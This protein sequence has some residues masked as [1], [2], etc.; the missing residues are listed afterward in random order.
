MKKRFSYLILATVVLVSGC[1]PQNRLTKSEK[2]DGWQLLF[3]GVTTTGWRT[4]YGTGFPSHGWMVK[5][6]ELRGELTAGSEA[7]DAGDIVTLKK[8]K[9]FELVFEWKLGN[10]GNSGIKY[11]I[12]ERLPKPSGSQPGYE[13]QLIDDATYIYNEKLLPQDLKTASI[14]DVVA[15]DKPD[16]SMNVW[17]HSK[18]LVNGNLIEHWLDAVKVLSVDR[19]NEVFIKGLADSKFHNYPG[20]GSLTEGHI[21]IQDH[22]HNVA[23]RSIKI[24]EL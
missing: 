19:T 1:S 18:I 11:F 15:A 24:K 12:E 17:H 10:G 20:F 4:S 16:V 6:G 7:G 8:Y 5:N 14:Y 23:F 13:Y 22:G 9:N 21:L 2:N 3:D